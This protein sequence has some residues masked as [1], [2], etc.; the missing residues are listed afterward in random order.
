MRIGVHLPTNFSKHDIFSELTTISNSICDIRGIPGIAGSTDKNFTVSKLLNGA[1]KTITAIKKIITELSAFIDPN[2]KE[3]THEYQCE[4]IMPTLDAIG[5][6]SLKEDINSLIAQLDLTL[7]VDAM[8]KKELKNVIDVCYNIKDLLSETRKIVQERKILVNS[9]SNHV[10]PENL[11]TLLENKLCVPNGNFETLYINFCELTKYGLHCEI[12]LSLYKRTETYTRYTA[13][14]YDGVQ[15]VAEH[16]SQ[17]FV[18]NSENQLGLLDCGDIKTLIFNPDDNPISTDLHCT[19][20]AYDNPCGLALESNDLTKMLTHCNFTYTEPELATRT[21]SGLLIMNDNKI[22]VIKEYGKD[23]KM[24]STI[25]NKTPVLIITDLTVSISTGNID[26]LF[27]PVFNVSERQIL[28]TYL[29]PE[30]IKGM[31]WSAKMRGLF[32]NVGHNEILHL[33][34]LIVLLIITPITIILCGLNI[35]NPACCRQLKMAKANK[36]VNKMGDVRANYKENKKLLK[37]ILK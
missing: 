9:L 25:P 26:L 34:T 28:Y 12:D 15:L 18:K 21:Q 27:E 23:Q 29:S 31:K 35:K 14:S 37:N 33:F 19:F 10:I 11:P 17:M 2:A 8:D 30:F 4:L 5:F 3:V 22:L 32:Q 1:E 24:K 13:V 20:T 16:V 6:K 36:V 7:A